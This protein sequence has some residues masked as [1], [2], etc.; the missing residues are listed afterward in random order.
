M[1]DIRQKKL[2]ILN[3]AAPAPVGNIPKFWNMANVDEDEAEITLYGEILSRR[4]IDW[5]TGEPEPGLFI[6]P[7]E[8]LEDLALIKDKGKITIRINSVGG[9]LYTGM[10]IYTQL[11]G[12]QGEKTV[13][14]DGIAAS[15]ASLIAMAGDTIKIPAGSLIMIHDPTV[16]LWDVYNVKALK[17]VIKMLDAAAQ[18]AAETYAVKTKLE[19][20]AIRSM[21]H[22]ET[23]MTGREAVEKGF[24]D[25]ILYE[26]EPQMVMSADRQVLMVNGVKQNIRGYRNIPDYIPVSSRITAS[27]NPQAVNKNNS[28]GGKKKM[29]K[30]VEELKQACPELVKQI[31]DTARE[32]G[33]KAGITEERTRLKAIEDI[34]AAIGDEKIVADA[35]YGEKPCT[36]EELAFKALQQQ[37]SLGKQFLQNLQQDH[38]NSGAADVGANPNAGNPTNLGETAED[39]KAAEAAAVAMIVGKNKKGDEKNDQKNA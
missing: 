31:E 9:D 12:L 22:K 38:D 2:R 33:R 16:Y 36:A 29:F 34:Q 37:A 4:P 23:W 3:G 15:A 1:M 19:V 13:I 11:K 20:D 25:E 35:K 14:I 18:S 7:E 24:A 39:E 6:C 5:W 30:T 10:A 26:D 27:A 17:E 32:E 8:F 21:M 28:E